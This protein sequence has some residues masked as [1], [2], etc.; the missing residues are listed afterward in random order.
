MIPDPPYDWTPYILKHGKSR[1][2]W[3][4]LRKEYPLLERDPRR[5]RKP[6]VI[7]DIDGVLADSHYR[8][9]LIRN[10]GWDAFYEA[11]AND[12]VVS[13]MKEVVNA[14]YRDGNEIIM[15][16]G[17]PERYYD[18]TTDWLMHHR[19]SFSDIIMRPD[20]SNVPGA[21]WKGEHYAALQGEYVIV[22]VFDDDPDIIGVAQTMG[23]PVVPIRSYINHKETK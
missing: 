20:T 8:I 13:G 14:L 19:I 7:C 12:P 6:A 15:L 3:D 11:A 18:L 17:R 9:P 21:V 1:T 2:L 10:R 4:L 16:T 5:W 23:L 22:A